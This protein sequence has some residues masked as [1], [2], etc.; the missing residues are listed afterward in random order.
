M[1]HI[2]RSMSVHLIGDMTRQVNPGDQVILSGIFMPKPYTGFKAI[3]AG[4]LTDTYLMASHIQQVKQKYESLQS[5]EDEILTEQVRAL[6]EDPEVNLKFRIF[7][8][9]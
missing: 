2:P 6:A 4:L 8:D 9:L 1:G 5:K 7:I 3:K